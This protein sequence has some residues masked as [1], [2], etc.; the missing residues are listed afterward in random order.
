MVRMLSRSCEFAVVDRTIPDRNDLRSPQWRHHH[1]RSA[2]SHA[3][4][5]SYGTIEVRF[6]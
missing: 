5:R 6:L 3:G 4:D 2:V 1:H